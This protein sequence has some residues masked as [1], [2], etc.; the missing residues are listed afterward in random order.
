M[1]SKQV[2]AGISVVL[3]VHG[4]AEYLME[5][6]R[7]VYSS[8]VQ[9]NEVLLIDDGV[10]TNVIKSVKLQFPNII[11]LAN[12][13][14]GLV[15]AL[16]TGVN[17]AHFDLI[18]RIDADDLLEPER[19]ETQLRLFRDNLELM[20]LGSQV[21]YIDK[22]G[23]LGSKSQYPVGDI[24]AET[25][26]GRSC[27]IAHPSVMYRKQA[28]ISAGGYRHIYRVNQM[29]LAEDFDLWIRVSRIGLIVNLDAALTRYRQHGAQ[30]SNLH[31]IPQEMASIYIKAVAHYETVS[32]TEADCVSIQRTEPILWASINFVFTQLGLRDAAR[33]FLEFLSFKGLLNSFLKRLLAIP[34]RF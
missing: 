32:S 4:P 23:N 7:S 6:L 8:T 10:D 28:V 1:S 33:Y 25:K 2:D 21:R 11:I 18:A 20:L 15:D 9:P 24:T 31:R 30:L 29:D 26:T 3:P 16:N 13:G 34:F 19:L 12:K 5:T 14:S 22:L 27:I 17:S